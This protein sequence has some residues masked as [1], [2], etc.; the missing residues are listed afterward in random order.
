VG[1]EQAFGGSRFVADATWFVN[2]YDDLIVGVRDAFAGASQYRTDNIANARSRG[3]EI[4]ARWIP[5]AGV[6]VRAAW[7]R[8]DTEVLGVDNVP[9]EAPPPFTVGGQLIRRPR[10]QGSLD[11]AWS[12]ARTAAFVTVNGRGRMT[13]LEPNLASTLVDNPGYAAVAAG[14]SVRVT[15]GVE[16][17]ARITN[18]FDRRYEETFGFPA[19]GRAAMIGIRVT[20]SR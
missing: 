6:S 1:V 13:D 8:L 15:R 11:V 5:A 4:G 9:S 17:Y 16:V 10:Q 19:P 20:G 18:L 7:T 14:A 12:N 3:L 2:R